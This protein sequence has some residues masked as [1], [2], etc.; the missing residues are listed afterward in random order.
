MV[1]YAVYVGSIS[2]TFTHLSYSKILC[3][4]PWT[5]NV[6]FPAYESVSN[7]S[8]VEIKRDGTTVFK[9]I[10]DKKI[11]SHTPEKADEV[12]LVGRSNAEKL[13]RYVTGVGEDVGEPATL[14]TNALTG[15]G[16]SA[17]TINTYGSNIK[18]RKDRQTRLAYIKRIAQQIGWEFKV[19]INDT[20]DFKQVIGVDRSSSIHILIGQTGVS[21]NW[22]EDWSQI[23]NRLYAFGKGDSEENRVTLPSPG[24]VED[25]ASQSQYGVREDM[26]I[27]KDISDSNVLL[28]LANAVLSK[29]K[30]PAY[31]YEVQLIDTM[32]TG[33]YEIGDMVKLTD[34][35]TGI[36]AQNFRIHEIHVS[37]S[38]ER[39]EDVRWVLSNKLSRLEDIFTDAQSYMDFILTNPQ[40][41]SK[42]TGLSVNSGADNDS[43]ASGAD[44]DSAGSNSDS[45]SESSTY[46]SDSAGST[47]DSD[48]A[49]SGSDSDSAANN[50]PYSNSAETTASNTNSLS[51]PVPSVSGN[52]PM[53]GL[54]V[55]AVVQK[56]PS[57]ATDYWVFLYFSDDGESGPTQ[58]FRGVNKFNTV[59]GEDYFHV[60]VW[61]PGDWGGKTVIVGIKD[62][63]G[64]VTPMNWVK[65]RV[66][67]YGAHTHGLTSPSHGHSITSPSHGHSVTSPSHGHGITSPS[68]GHSVTSPSHGHGITSPSHGHGTSETSHTH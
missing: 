53:W 7:G 61:L 2:K 12:M 60:N 65:L 19:N 39:G 20:L 30:N 41:F 3:K 4:D 67:S 27:A 25:A 8:T 46:D 49:A 66:T 34:Q 17:G 5:F 56:S 43:V 55:Y 10:L 35:A 13:E 9:G 42:I 11:P 58:F 50:N 45:D 24:Y 51:I 48:S 59:G 63:N 44:S 38:A 52:T 62:A 33:A 14:V 32:T 31:T 1:S 6:T 57:T 28:T 15:T 21:V 23:K 36:N 40:L 26:V 18:V 47:A 64:N 37:Y 68:H 54:H 29:V 22:F 16:I